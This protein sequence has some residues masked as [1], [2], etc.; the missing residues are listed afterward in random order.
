[1]FKS[2]F[3]KLKSMNLRLRHF[4]CGLAFFLALIPN[5]ADAQD[6]DLGNWL[7]YIGS[8]KISQNWN[9]HHEIQNRNYNTFGDL[10]Q[11]LIRTGLGYTLRDKNQNL[12]LGY[13]YI[14]SE[15]Y[16][17]LDQ[18]TPINEH[19]VFQQFILK[20]T[21][22]DF[23][24]GHRFRLEQRFIES[25]FK[26]RFRYFLN[27]R[28]TLKIGRENRFYLSAYNEFFLSF[29]EVFFDRNRLYGGIGYKLSEGINLEMGYMN[30]FLGFSSRDQLNLIMFLNL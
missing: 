5:S 8:K 26:I 1:M 27:A 19:R 30:Q 4:F 17:E 23:K 16:N 22:N 20:Q 10:E 29:E 11:L 15:N 6:S 2:A 14:L 3:L 28:L 13:G 9:W 12:L 18:K 7:I 24:L 21:I 25:E